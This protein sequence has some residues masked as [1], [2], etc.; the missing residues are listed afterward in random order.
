MDKRARG[1]AL[2]PPVTR[3]LVLRPAAK[4]EL[5]AVIQWYEQ[6]RDGLGAEFLNAMDRTLEAI[7]EA[8]TSYPIWPADPR[9]RKK[10]VERFPYIVFFTVSPVLVRIVAIAHQRRAPGYWQNR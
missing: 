8:P 6:Q 3:R 2:E 9:V 1:A 5:R 7:L 10:L 4:A